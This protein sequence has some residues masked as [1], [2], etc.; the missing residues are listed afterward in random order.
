MKHLDSKQTLNE[1][2]RIDNEVDSG[3]A[4]YLS[5][6]PSCRSELLRR[7]LMGLVRQRTLLQMRIE[8]KLK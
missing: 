7:E 5:A 3:L 4:L 1:I 8:G 6:P 2:K